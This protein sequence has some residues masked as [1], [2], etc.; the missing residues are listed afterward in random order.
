MIGHAFPLHDMGK[1]GIPDCVLLK[2]GK[3]DP[4]EFEIMQEQASTASGPSNR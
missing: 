1:V 3:L 2:P 4:E